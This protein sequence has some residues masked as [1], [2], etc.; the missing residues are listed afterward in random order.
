MLS[1]NG[2]NVCHGGP[3][4]SLEIPEEYLPI[5]RQA[6]DIIQNRIRGQYHCDEIFAALPGG[7][8]FRDLFDDPNTW[9]NYD[10]SG[11]QNDWGWT[12]PRSFPN[13]LVVTQFTLRMG[14]W[15]TAGTIIHELA[16]LNGA[17]GGNSHAAEETLR[18]CGLQSPRGPYNPRIRG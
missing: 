6:L 2:D 15:S 3:P 10:P 12:M 16:H 17:P 14:R 4:G 9:I 5:V 8:N 18:F 7:H 1:I 13:D 11:R